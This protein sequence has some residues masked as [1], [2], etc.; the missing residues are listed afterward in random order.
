MPFAIRGVL[1][2]QGESGTAIG[3][4]DQY[5]LMGALIAGWRKEWGQDDFPFLYIQKPSGDGCA[6]DTSNPT[7]S[8]ANKFL[9]L[10]AQ[11]PNDGQ[12]RAMH[13]RIMTYPN[14][15]MV[16][17]S[18]LGNGVHPINKSGY[19]ERASRVALG[20]V[21]GRKLEIYGPVYKSHTVEGDKI[22]VAFDHVGQGLAY[23]HGDKL[24]GFALAG[25][26]K[27]FHWADAL[28]DGN[29]IVLSCPA[30]TR[31]VAVRYAWSQNQAWAN[32]FN[33]DGLPAISFRTDSW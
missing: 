20:M 12:Y 30:V 9:P 18:D 22:R 24:Q 26:D 31:P 16:T 6:W 33:R 11:V 7:T 28:I 2:D 3:G 19:G 29:S 21:Y 15:A 4:V 8:Q 10:P 23:Q 1:W 17:S 25:D 13:I 14:T 27:K 32:L 5:N